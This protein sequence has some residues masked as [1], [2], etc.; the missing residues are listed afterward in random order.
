MFTISNDY[1]ITWNGRKTTF[2]LPDKQVRN[3]DNDIKIKFYQRGKR[4]I[5]TAS[6]SLLN[7]KFKKPRNETQLYINGKYFVQ[8]SWSLSEENKKVITQ[9]II[10]LYCYGYD[11][12]DI[13]Q[14][15]KQAFYQR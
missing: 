15:L 12:P 11:L 4:G 8:L 5:Y 6:Q 9:M 2:K 10:I 7:G 1:T 14:A 3:W 13:K